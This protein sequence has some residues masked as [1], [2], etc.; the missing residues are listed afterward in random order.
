M[1]ASFEEFVKY[2]GDHSDMDYLRDHYPR[3]LATRKLAY[4]D[5]EW[6]RA[7]ILDIGA[8]WLHQSLLYALDGHHVTATDFPNQI[9]DPINQGVASRH[10][11]DLFGYEDLSSESVFDELPND[12]MDVVL[13]SE[14][15]EHITFNPVRMWKAIYRVLRPGGRIILT[16]PNFYRTENILSS[17]LRFFR[18]LGSGISI[19]DILELETFGP[20]WKEY[21]K[22]EIKSYF[23]LLSPDFSV[24]RDVYVDFEIEYLHLNWKGIL[25]YRTS[26][27]VPFLR[28]GIFAS[29]ELREKSAGITIDP[30]WGRKTDG[31]SLAHD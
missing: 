16:T 28:S 2:L 9:F 19:A 31:L 8:H 29:I 23:G 12:S 18:G 5:W 4:E 7:D 24:V 6:K 17:L 20:H 21:S 3:F 22:K 11:I 1:S 15:L 14:I 13:F 26:K 25:V 30:G 27:I 10:G